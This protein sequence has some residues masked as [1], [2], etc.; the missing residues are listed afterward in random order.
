[1][2]LLLLW[3]ENWN[4]CFLICN[5]DANLFANQNK[6][7]LNIYF[8]PYSSLTLRKMESKLEKNEKYPSKSADLEGYGDL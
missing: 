2:H 6:P 4:Y 5:N 8:S 7:Q 3:R 1:M